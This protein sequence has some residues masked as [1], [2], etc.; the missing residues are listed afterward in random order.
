[1]RGVRSRLDRAWSR[2]AARGGP[3]SW[4][5]VGRG[6]GRV[7]VRTAQRD[8]RS[9]KHRA[10]GDG[11]RVPCAPDLAKL[12]VK[13]L[14]RWGTDDDGR[15]FTGEHGGELA[16]ITYVRLWDRARSAALTPEQTASPLARRPYDLR[17]A[18]VSTWLTS[19][20]PAAQVVS[21]AGHSVAVLHDVYAKC[22]D[23]HEELSLERLREAYGS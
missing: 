9:L 11:R 19:G 3:S 8:Q 2:W 15:L 14:E 20:V 4:L 21:W 6:V 10:V 13:H 16:T 1:M 18:A 12:L 5:P 7:P 17:H 22:L 23:G